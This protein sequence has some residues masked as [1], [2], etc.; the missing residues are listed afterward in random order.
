MSYAFAL[1][2]AYNQSGKYKESIDLMIFLSQQTNDKNLLSL[3]YYNIANNYLSLK[4]VD[5]ALEYA[6]KA[7][8]SANT[9]DNR[10]LV[11]Y[12]KYCKGNLDSAE[13]EFIF[14]LRKNPGYTN[15]ALGLADVYIKKKKYFEARKVLKQLIKYNPEA[16]NDKS[17]NAYKIYTIF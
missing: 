3:L 10:S 11:A 4:D 1:A 5:K 8:G 7:L 12:V 9:L 6:K 13:K 15:A 16:L 17:L 2:D 14:I